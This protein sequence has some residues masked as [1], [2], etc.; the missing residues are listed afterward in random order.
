MA[1][2]IPLLSS[3]LLPLAGYRNYRGANNAATPNTK[4]DVSVDAAILED[5]NGNALKFGSKSLTIDCGAT[6]A[7]GM[8]TGSLAASTWYYVFLVSNGATVAGLISLSAT[9][10]TLPSGY[11]Y[12]LFLGAVQTDASSHLLS[13]AHMD[14]LCS[15]AARN[16]YF[17]TTGVPTT[18]TALN[19][20]SLVPPSAKTVDGIVG[21][22]NGNFCASFVASSSDGKSAKIGFFPAFG[23]TLDNWNGGSNFENLPILTSQTIYQKS[24]VSTGEMRVDITGF[25]V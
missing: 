3:G 19:I 18:Y 8:D 9:A 14:N 16:A 15:F 23:T 5:T 6:G 1:G 7:N 11:S 21:A 22:G 2:I 10:P 24:F 4:W 13:F 12:K 25:R 20:A 17:A